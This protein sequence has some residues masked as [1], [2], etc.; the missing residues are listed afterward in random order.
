MAGKILITPYQGSTTVGQDPTI[1]FQ[2]VSKSTDITLRVSADG[3]LSFEGL[4]GQLFSIADTM[5]GTIF[6]VNDISGIP[7]IEVLDTGNIKLA[8]YGG[9]VGIGTSTPTYKLDI[10]DSTNASIRTLSGTKYITQ[11]SY[12]A[13]ANYTYSYGAGYII[14]TG[15][16]NNLRLYTNNLE[17]M[18]LHASGGLS[19]GNT[20]DP[21]AS[22]LSISSNI[23]FPKTTNTGIQV[24]TTTPT[25]GWRDIIGD[26][27]LRGTGAADP[28]YS[29]YQ[30]SIRAY[31][32][33]ASILQ[34]VQVVF[35]IPHDYVP[36]SDIYLH[37]HWS[38]GAT[39]PNTGN[40]V[41]GFEVSWAKGFGQNAFSTPTTYTVTQ[42]SPAI[43]Y[44]GNIGE[45]TAITLTG[46]EVDSLILV[47]VYRDATNVADTCTD[48]VFLHTADV[49]Y[50]ST[51]LATKAKVGP[52]FY[53]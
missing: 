33:S 35:H 28:S 47:R 29:I 50:Q 6:S 14:G 38:N 3:I 32:F 20:T 12:A 36:G 43:R 10:Q 1:K 39:V 5:T 34:E 11:S 25:W 44:T 19:I 30:G 27:S 16:A 42:A 22:N 53:T 8:Q 7:S 2:G 51:N 18:R 21:G 23:I 40:V 48:P 45:T 24:D 9:N 17:R 15:D 26:I 41:W 37:A 46:L 49:H 52:A 13:D 31:S 4:S